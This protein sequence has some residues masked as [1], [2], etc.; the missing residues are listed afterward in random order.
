[1]YKKYYQKNSKTKFRL[2]IFQPILPRS[3]LLTIYK[4]LIRGQLDHANIIYDQTYNSVFLNKLESVQYNACLVIT[5]A[6]RGSSA[7]KLDQELGIS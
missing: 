2:R 5:G 1:M 3:F 4:T 7:E 6:V